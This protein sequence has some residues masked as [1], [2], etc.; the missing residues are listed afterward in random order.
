MRRFTYYFL[1][2]AGL[3]MAGACEKGAETQQEKPSAAGLPIQ[4]E[5]VITRVTE[6]DFESGDAIGLTVTRAAGT[7]AANEKLVYDGKTFSGPLVWYAEGADEATLSAYSP[8]QAS[9]VPSSFTVA[10]DQSAGTSSSDFLAASKTGVVPSANAV[11]MVFT[12]RLARLVIKVQNNS[13]KEITGVTVGGARLSTAL[14]EDFTATVDPAAPVAP[15]K[16]FKAAE[17]TWYAIL[18]PQKAALSVKVESELSL[19]PQYLAEAELQAGKQYSVGVVVNPDGLM[20]T[21]SGNIEN[22]TDGGE[23]DPG[24]NPPAV[25]FEENLDQKYFVYAGT[26]YPLVKMKDGKWWM[27][28]NLAY[29]PAGKTAATDLTAVTAGVFAP[30]RV[31]GSGAAE[32][33]TD[34]AVIASNGYLYQAEFAMGLEVGTL[35]GMDPVKALERAAA[36]EGV[37]GICPPGWHVPTLA[38]IQGLVG[39]VVGRTSITTPYFDPNSMTNCLIEALNADGFNM[40]AYGFISITDNTKSNGTFS[41]VANNRFSSGMFCGSSVKLERVE[42]EDNEG[43]KVYE[44]KPVATYNDSKVGISSGIKNFLFYGFMPMNNQGSCNGTNVAYRLGA[45]L[46]CVRDKSE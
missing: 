45:P 32:F 23:L 20:V 34:A 3:L 18:P 9:G 21:L 11:A 6:T 2:A 5:P 44:D 39:K 13:G 7:Y 10:S 42:I 28:R 15:V 36:L 14:S 19:A 33:S 12:H 22:W 24:N 40:A 29:L 41:P 37:Q 25:D 31:G 1:L 16:A 8:W 27:A 35:D 26:R 4:V 17:K 46:R 38:D 43:N 30:I